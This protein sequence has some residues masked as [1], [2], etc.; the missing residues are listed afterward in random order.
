MSAVLSL[1]FAR[2]ESVCNVLEMAMDSEQASQLRKL[3]AEVN[4]AVEARIRGDAGAV[5]RVR[6]S[7]QAVQMVGMGP[8]EYW[9][10]QLWQVS[11]CR[12]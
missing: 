9:G 2:Q 4:D 11:I 12:Y 3:A 1:D 10:N 8:F 5:E 6:R 7:T